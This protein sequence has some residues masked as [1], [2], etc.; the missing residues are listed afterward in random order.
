[1]KTS[2]ILATLGVVSSVVADDV[3]YSKRHLS[4]RFID[5]DGNYNMSTSKL[6]GHVKEV[7][8]NE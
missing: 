6:D 7:L 2:A 5:N 1:M 4:K 3:L 8:A